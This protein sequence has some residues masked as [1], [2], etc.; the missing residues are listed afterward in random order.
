VSQAQRLEV[1]YANDFDDFGVEAYTSVFVECQGKQEHPML[2]RSPLD[3]G[4]FVGK[5]LVRAYTPM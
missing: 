4:C 5:R 2:A 3:I 1:A